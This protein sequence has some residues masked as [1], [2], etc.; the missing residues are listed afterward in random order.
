MKNLKTLLMASFLTVGI[1]S[2][3]VFTSCNGDKCKDTV[4]NNGG[5]CNESDGS[6]SCAVGYEGSN[7]ETLSKT[8]FIKSWSASD[9]TGGNALVYT[10]AIATGANANAVIIANDFSDDYFVNNIAATVDKNTITIATQQPDNDGYEVWGT[11]TFS[12][13]TISW[14]Y[15]IREVLTNT[16][17]NYTGVWQ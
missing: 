9:A 12:S 11:G 14:T 7:C 15:S 16:T 5:T 3:V 17:L 10:C 13:N 8:K 2:T 4:C 1:F 6:C